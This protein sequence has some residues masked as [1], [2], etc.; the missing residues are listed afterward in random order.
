MI[1][2]SFSLPR[3]HIDIDMN[4]TIPS[5]GIT[6]IFGRSGAGKTTVIDVVSGLITPTKGR[7]KVG[8][9][10]LFDS[11]LGVN[12][13]PEKRH[14]GYVFQDARLF[15]HMTVEKNLTYG[16]REVNTQKYAEIIAFLDLNALIKRYPKQL[17]GGEKQRVAIGRA[18]LSNP[19][20]LIMDEPTASLD[21]PRRAELISY[22]LR[23]NESLQI[24]VLYVS[25]SLDEILQL[26]DHMLLLDKGK[27][28]VNGPIFDVWGSAHMRPWFAVKEQ[29]SLVLASVVKAHPDY[30][31]TA[32]E[33]DGERVWVPKIDAKKGT[34]LRLRV[35]ATDISVV[36]SRP[37]DSSIRN[38]I[39]VIIDAVILHG[40]AETTDTLPVCY[41]QLR[42][43]E[44]TL[45]ASVTQWAVDELKLTQGMRVFAQIKAVNI[46]KSDV[47]PAH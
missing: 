24:P 29:S 33:V 19:Q 3:E 20:L 43:A 15:P 16:Q 41:L 37:T 25:H 12:L 34:N 10:L 30:P 46:T 8:N 44:Q 21:L 39:P 1:T 6:A 11:E 38:I 31:L 26:A 2:L 40:A 32:L 14:I 28:L 35:L 18:L 45:L 7:I 5:S 17:S 47:A 27:V 13:A 23:L 9:Q 36:K 4:E 22:L 42:I